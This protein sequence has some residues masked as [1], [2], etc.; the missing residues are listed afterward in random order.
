MHAYMTT[1][2]RIVIPLEIRRKFGLKEGVRVQVGMDELTH[3]IILTPVT[4]EHIR[5]QCGKYK[6]KRLLE[7]LAVEKNRSKN[8]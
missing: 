1:K 3:K 2:G 7:A 4:R 8:S 5:R 6:G